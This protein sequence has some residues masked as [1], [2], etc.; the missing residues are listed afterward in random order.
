MKT[1]IT[2]ISRLKMNELDD[3]T[4]GMSD[5]TG[6]FRFVHDLEKLT[7]AAIG[8][9]LRDAGIDYPAGED[10][11]AL[12]IGIDDAV[13]CIKNE[14]FENVLREGVLG[15]S[16]LLF[17]FTSPNALAARATIL[18]DLRGESAVFAV[19]D[20]ID[21]VIEYAD[22]SISGQSVRMAIAGGITAVDGPDNCQAVFYFLE[23]D[24]SARARG[25]RI[26]KDLQEAAK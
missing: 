26:Y 12:F 19:R 13:E 17:P 15:A 20:S 22:E 14:F 9:L 16:P 3:V 23:N 2:G 1:V 4:A 21:S 5:G 18:F 8:M 10:N 11:I 6:S 24:D 25:A 7:V